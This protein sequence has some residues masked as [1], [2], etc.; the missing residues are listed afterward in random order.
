MTRHELRAAGVTIAL[1]ERPL[2]MG[3]VNATPDSFS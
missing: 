2:L 3:I 1:G